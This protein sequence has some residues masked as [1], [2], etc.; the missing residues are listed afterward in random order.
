MCLV[1]NNINNSSSSSS[2]IIVTDVVACLQEVRLGVPDM[3]G[4]AGS[5]S[6]MT[7]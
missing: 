7:V 1:D 4:A 2:K 3:P 6:Y 5:G